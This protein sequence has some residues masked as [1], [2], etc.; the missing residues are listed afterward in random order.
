[1]L[2]LKLSFYYLII[3]GGSKSY[4]RIQSRM[5]IPRR[6]WQEIH[7]FRRLISFYQIENGNGKI[8]VYKGFW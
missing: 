8:N 1:M 2:H 3:L 5:L 6:K 4:Y 7:G